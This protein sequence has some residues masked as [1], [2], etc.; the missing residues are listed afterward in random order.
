MILAAALLQI[1]DI[2][3]IDQNIKLGFFVLYIL[4]NAHTLAGNTGT[5]PSHSSSS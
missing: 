1:L 2:A 3:Y 5:L 4:H